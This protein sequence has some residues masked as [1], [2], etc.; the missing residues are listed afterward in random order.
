VSVEGSNPF[1]RSIF[2][3]PSLPSRNPL[4]KDIP[5]A[6]KSFRLLFSATPFPGYSLK[7]EWAR[8]EYGGNWYLSPDLKMEGWLCPALFKYFQK[9]PNEIYVKAEAA[10]KASA[11]LHFTLSRQAWALGLQ[12]FDN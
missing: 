2:S 3:Y 4:V 9:A 11:Q 1:A 5:N 6:Q 12:P 8:E 10:T 7:L